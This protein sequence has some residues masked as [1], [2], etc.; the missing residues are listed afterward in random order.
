ML[1]VPKR[2]S[3]SPRLYKRLLFVVGWINLDIL[4]GIHFDSIKGKEFNGCFL[5]ISNISQV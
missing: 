4:C 2:K 1:Y 5:T 3:I